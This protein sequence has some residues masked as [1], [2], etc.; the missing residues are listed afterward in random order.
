M[1]GV[2]KLAH[3]FCL[4]MTLRQIDFVLGDSGTRNAGRKRTNLSLIHLVYH[5]F[6]FIWIRIKRLLTDIL[7]FLNLISTCEFFQ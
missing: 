4:L 3:I 5:L 7:K 1:S 6:I 2:G